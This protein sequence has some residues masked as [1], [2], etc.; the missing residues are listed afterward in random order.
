MGTGFG[1]E[2]QIARDAAGAGESGQVLSGRD[3]GSG[4]WRGFDFIARGIARFLA[5][6]HG[7]DRH[8]AEDLAQIAMLR[9]FNSELKGVRVRSQRAWLRTVIANLAVDHTRQGAI[10]GVGYAP[11]PSS[12]SPPE[13]LADSGQHS[14]SER[15]MLSEA[16]TWARQCLRRLPSPYAQIA[17]LQYLKGHTRREIAVWLM[18]WRPVK[19]ETCRGLILATHAMLRSLSGIGPEALW[20]RRYDSRK[21]PWLLTP[22]PPHFP[23][24]IHRGLD[25]EIGTSGGRSFPLSWLGSQGCEGSLAC[26]MPVL[27]ASWHFLKS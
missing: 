19:A 2:T 17:R 25:T 15:L 4:R 3:G 5:K 9:L 10:P 22:P 12:A 14:P 18:S 26:L 20:P 23:V 6:R 1:D 7:W 11:I 24:C 16:S 13:L 8:A 27:S 21:N